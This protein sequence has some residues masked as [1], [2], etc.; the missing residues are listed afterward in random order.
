M[1]TNQEKV[2]KKKTQ[3]STDVADV[4]HFPEVQKALQESHKKLDELASESDQTR[5]E[6]LRDGDVK[7]ALLNL[8]QVAEA[9][10]NEKR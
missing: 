2:N 5:Y 4:S 6:A 7:K 3:I 1:E 8:Q 10:R 9:T